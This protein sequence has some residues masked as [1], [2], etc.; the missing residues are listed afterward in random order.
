MRNIQMLVVSRTLSVGS[1]LGIASLVLG[2]GC[3]NGS[4]PYETAGAQAVTSDAGTATKEQSSEAAGKAG[5]H[6]DEAGKTAERQTS[7]DMSSSS[8]SG[9]AVSK[10]GAGIGGVGTASAAG[11]KSANDAGGSN[12]GGSAHDGAAAG[13]PAPECGKVGQACCASNACT[14]DAV[15]QDA[16]CFSCGHPGEPCCAGSC[17]SGCCVESRCLAVGASCGGNSGTCMSDGC[18]GCGSSAQLCCPGG[19]CHAGLACT[20]NSP[21]AAAS[22]PPS[23]LTCSVCGKADEACCPDRTCSAGVCVGNGAGGE[24]CRTN[25][26]TEGQACC[27]LASGASCGAGLNCTN[28]I[29]SKCGG[30]G[31]P[32]CAGAASCESSLVCA[33][34]KCVTCGK[35]GQPCC[36][37]SLGNDG[38]SG[39][40]TC[41]LARCT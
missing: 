29:C 32:C 31:E 4:S 17:G 1:W 37:Q 41:V 27:Q 30:E 10:G 12:A 20:S 22:F 13:K 36:Q 39:Q 11:A 2:S 5:S 19:G 35:P 24:V 38:C 14:S 6:N 23:M 28:Q 3:H 7:T 40:S 16:K 21:T 33:D 15:C 25:C 18:S 9:G 34:S 26:G 8:G